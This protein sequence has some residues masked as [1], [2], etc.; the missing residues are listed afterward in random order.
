M[1]KRGEIFQITEHT[2]LHID[3][4]TT[5]EEST[6]LQDEL[7]RIYLHPTFVN[8]YTVSAQLQTPD[9]MHWDKMERVRQTW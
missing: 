8:I 2:H 4:T 7:E 1:Y 5:F 6:T 3:C 9:C